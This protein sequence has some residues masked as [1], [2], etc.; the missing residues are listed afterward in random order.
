[1]SLTAQ[2]ALHLPIAA[3]TD[4]QITPRLRPASQVLA[5]F[6]C[7]FLA[8]LDLYCTQPL[9][10]F[11]SNAFHASEARVGLTISAST[12]G[13]AFSAL[14]LAIFAE[15]VNRKKM[16][17][18]SMVALAC[19]ALLTATATNLAWLAAWRLLQGL[20][21]PGIFT[22]TIAYLTEEWPPLLV[23]R[24]MSVYVAGTVFG[25]FV[26]R[27]SGGLLAEHYGWRVVFVVLGLLGLV[28]AFVTSRLLHPA[29]L[30]VVPA[31]PR[32]RLTPVFENLRNPRLLATF[33]IGFCMLFALVA[34]FSYITFHLAAA[35]F[36][37]ST[38]ALSWLF[39]VYLFGL[40]A[41]L[42][43]GS[44]LARVGLRHG[45]LGAVGLCLAGAG[46]TLVPSLIVAAIGL[47]LA[48]S[49]VFIAQTCANSFLRDA[50]PAG[51]RVSAAGMYICSYY[52]GG[53][54]GGFLPG[55]FWKQAGWAG[56]VG[57]TCC[58]LVTAG[59]TAYYGWRPRNLQA[60]PIPL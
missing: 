53:T 48:S 47:S 31:R 18:W 25:G 2:P 52:I 55:L 5:A 44:M 22:I 60:D 33:A 10:P 28:G 54:V 13:V 29:R 19:I 4:E 40:V 56:C 36:D 42:V 11:L 45:M 3:R 23:P 8:F 1:M 17:V 6:L 27:V 26:G 7:G 46:L 15:R 58:L 14:M 39:S 16:I 59:F 41:T 34:I 21:T 20:V 43:V 24:I 35:P 32:S 50:A 30:R 38:S 37:L 12:L 57:V 51:S 9:L 49:G